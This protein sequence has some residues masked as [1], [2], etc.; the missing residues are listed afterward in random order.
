MVMASTMAE[1]T[2]TVIESQCPPLTGLLISP[3]SV[4]QCPC[5]PSPLA[6][7]AVL[8]EYTLSPHGA[9]DPAGAYSSGLTAILRGLSLPSVPPLPSSPI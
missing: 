3:S 8:P 9:P 6:Q 7:S 2:W 4:S 1:S 5:L